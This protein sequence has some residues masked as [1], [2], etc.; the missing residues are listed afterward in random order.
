MSSLKFSRI[1]IR[2]G[3]FSKAQLP[4]DGKLRL[5]C[6]SRADDYERL[7]AAR[8]QDQSVEL[9]PVAQRLRT[10]RPVLDEMPFYVVPRSRGKQVAIQSCIIH[11]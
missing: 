7:I 2:L 6:F 11:R 3:I 9:L 8:R 1:T 4:V 5:A 10:G